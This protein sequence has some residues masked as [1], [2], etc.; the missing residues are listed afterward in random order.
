MSMG[1]GSQE[2]IY[3]YFSLED[4]V[5]EDHLLRKIKKAVDFS[6]VYDLVKDLY[7][8]TGAPSIDPVVVFKLSLLGYLYNIP[9]ERRIVEDASL[10]MAYRWFLDYSLTQKL[11]D[12]SIFTKVRS[13]FGVEAYRRFFE[14]VV[15]SCV[16]AG[17]VEGETVFMDA[18]LIQAD[19]SEDGI[20]SR[21]LAKQLKSKADKYLEDLSWEDEELTPSAKV[22]RVLMNPDDPDAR[23][24]RHKNKKPQ[25]A[26]KGHLAVDGGEARIITAAEMSGG[27]FPEEHLMWRML[28]SHEGLSGVAVKS[29]CADTRYGT[30]DNYRLL[31]VKN[32]LPAIPLRKGGAKPTGYT[33]ENFTYDKETDS[34]TCPRN[35]K[36]LPAKPVGFYLPYRSR[37]FDC[38][39]C[40]VK[41]AC[42]AEG[43]RKTVMV[44][45][46][47]RIRLW[48]RSQLALPFAKELLRRRKIWP[49][50][51]FGTAKTQHGLRRAKY[52]G[53]WKVEIQL[54]MTAMA[55][56]LK[57]LAR[58]GGYTEGRAFEKINQLVKRLS[59]CFSGFLNLLQPVFE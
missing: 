1:K 43:D 45:K 57:K 24:V 50:T 36:L 18:T 25:L 44:S 30:S 42:I 59:D 2:E 49:E 12:H 31:K 41:S 40:Q 51:I 20:R 55:M 28:V 38:N 14:E 33:K 52:R 10:N 54:L 19:V 27:T 37:K 56:N 9:S 3:T 29:L 8:H 26:Y 48:A 4:V 35:K 21:A 47:H 23:I 46:N 17:L 16:K 39:R 7:S 6:F 22:N 32:I 58:Y 15:S 34:F 13:R 11:P 5:P 53:R